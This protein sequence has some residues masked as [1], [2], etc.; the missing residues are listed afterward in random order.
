MHEDLRQTPKPTFKKKYLGM[1]EYTYN[2]STREA[3]QRQAGPWGLQASQ[4][5][6][7][8]ELQAKL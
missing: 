4:P 3:R 1:M 6:L 8:G 2:T 5:R 7:T